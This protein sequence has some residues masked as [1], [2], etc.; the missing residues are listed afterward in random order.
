MSKTSKRIEEL[1]AKLKEEGLSDDEQAELNALENVSTP[2][3]DDKVKTPFDDD[4]KK[5]KKDESKKV[6]LGEGQVVVDSK[7]LDSILTLI[8]EQQEQINALK[9]EG[10]EKK[11]EKP[12]TPTAF[13]KVME[14]KEGKEQ[15]VVG[16]KSSPDC[17]LVF[18]PSN[19]TSPIGEVLQAEYFFKSGGSTG[20]I[21]QIKF[22][23]VLERANLEILSRDGNTCKVRMIDTA[24]W[25]DDVFDV[26]VAFLNP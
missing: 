25:G 7:K 12:K 14:D 6:E 13:L 9:L 11:E 23:K 15:L 2:F 5:G 16:W 24:K 3:D 21:D 18:H 20:V 1:Q 10:S 4:S 26:D 22:T 19:P 8:R 17:R